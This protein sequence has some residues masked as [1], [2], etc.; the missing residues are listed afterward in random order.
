MAAAAKKKGVT[1]A[2]VD[3]IIVA[4]A[5]EHG[6]DLPPILRQPVK[7][8]KSMNGEFDSWDCPDGSSR[9]K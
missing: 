9:V 4:T 2:V 3:G 7:S 5:L 6:L 8:R 1:L